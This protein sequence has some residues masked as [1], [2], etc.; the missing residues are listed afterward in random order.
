MPQLLIF[1]AA[2]AG[3]FLARKWYR[4][5]QHRIAKDIARAR[6]AMERR[7]QESAIPL[8]RDPATGVYRPR[9]KIH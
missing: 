2:G 3:L 1:L 5:E 4:D 8:E 7:D 6:E 9:A